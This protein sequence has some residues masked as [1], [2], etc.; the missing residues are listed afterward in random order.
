MNK[1]WHRITHKLSGALHR[2]LLFVTSYENPFDPS[3]IMLVFRCDK[4]NRKFKYVIKKDIY[5]A[6]KKSS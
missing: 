5:L 2:D 3:S 1:L 4:C 6:Q